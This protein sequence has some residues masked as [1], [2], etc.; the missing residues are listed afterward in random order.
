MDE[1]LQHLGAPLMFIHKSNPVR[2]KK[3]RD[4]ARDESC[5]LR[6]PSICSG[7]PATT[8]LAHLP[9][10]GRGVALKASDDHA[11]YACDA[12]H[13]VLDSRTRARID[14]AELYECCLRALAETHERM[15]QKG[16]ISYRG[17]A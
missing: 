3:L 13:S 11:V 17:A 4:S 5:T 1:G 7:D 14:R 6:L 10:G 15:R 12:C 8:V 16:L 9:F 2:S